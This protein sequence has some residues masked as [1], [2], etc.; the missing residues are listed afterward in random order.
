MNSRRTF[1][2]REAYDYDANRILYVMQHGAEEIHRLHIVG[3]RQAWEWVESGSGQVGNC[4]LKRSTHN[5]LRSSTIEPEDQKRIFLAHLTFSALV[6]AT[7]RYI[8]VLGGL[9][10]FR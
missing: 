10:E 8:T 7:T 9:E 4:V 3:Q 5:D 6:V 1:T 2:I